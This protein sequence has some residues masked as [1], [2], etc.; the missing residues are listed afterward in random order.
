VT[1][2]NVKQRLELFRKTREQLSFTLLGGWNSAKTGFFHTKNQATQ[3]RSGSSCTQTTKLI[4]FQHS[5]RK[6]CGSES[7]AFGQVGS[8]TAI[9]VPDPAFWHKNLHNFLQI[10]TDVFDYMIT[11]LFPP[12]I[13]EMLKKSS[14]IT[15]YI[16][17]K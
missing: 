6:C 2:T 13:C 12:K 16:L 10:C 17:Y 5:S 1:D 4:N 15:V 9:I 11:C 7:G 14:C 8:G 3:G